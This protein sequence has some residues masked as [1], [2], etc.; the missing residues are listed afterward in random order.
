MVNVMSLHYKV[1]QKEN[2]FLEKI[3]I[4]TYHDGFNYGAYLQVYSL[5]NYIKRCGL[6]VE[7][8]NY[9]NVRHWYNEYKCILSTKNPLLLF[10]MVRKVLAFKK[11]QSLLPT[12]KFTFNAN[13]ISNKRFGTVVVGSDEIWNYQQPLVGFDLTYFGK[14]ISADR[15]IS[16]AASFGAVDGEEEAI[17]FEINS[18]L[19]KFD[20]ISVRDS[21]SLS[22]L[23][24][25]GRKDAV[26]VVDPVFLIDIPI[27]DTHINEEDFILIYT[28]DLT[29]DLQEEIRSYANK[30]GKELISLGYMKRWCDRNI[31]AIDPFTC[32]AYFKKASF[33]ITSMFHGTMFSIK[34][35][36]QFCTL[37]DPYRTN[38][39]NPIM[40]KLLLSQRI[41]GKRVSLEEILDNNIDYSRV[42]ELLTP[43]VNT[44]MKYLNEALLL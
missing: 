34:Y 22:I 43:L 11:S 31:I 28:T 42:N 36:K 32:L 44:S 19:K 17:P 39:F 40:E 7:I 1:E 24:R 4:L 10:N 27:N 38:K 25:I 14:N 5:Y 3:G 2:K 37:V 18:L 23:E 8:I 29:K 30:I 12:G 6:N 9:K 26:L 21:N 41:K 35:G 15:L 13:K 16:Y 33:V 20:K